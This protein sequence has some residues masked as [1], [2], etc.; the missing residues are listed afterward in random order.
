MSWTPAVERALPDGWR[1]AALGVSSCPFAL[2]SVDEKHGRSA[3]PTACEEARNRDID[4]ALGAQPELVVVASA[5]GSF[6]RLTSGATGQSAVAEWQAGLEKALDRFREAEVPVVVLGNPPET[7]A[8]AD[9][10][11]RSGR[12]ADCVRPPS[13]AYEF[14]ARAEK[15]AVESARD[16]GMTV[17]Y[18]DPTGWFCVP[19][20]G[21]PPGVDGVL[22][23]LDHGHLTET[24]SAMLGPLLRAELSVAVTGR[25]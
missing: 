20:L 3:F 16:T 12:P 17:D 23:K 2:V 13:S 24:Y 1:V 19:G 21:C 9:C 22:A 14:K 6:T 4:A 5:E 7:T 8:A 10:A 18:I 11:V 15:A 25:G